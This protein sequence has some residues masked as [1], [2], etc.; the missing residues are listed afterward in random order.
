MTILT[1]LILT[2]CLT[3]ILTVAIVISLAAAD[4]LEQRRP[5]QPFTQA[6]IDEVQK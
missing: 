2:A 5:K 1:I 6:S 3:S 4:R